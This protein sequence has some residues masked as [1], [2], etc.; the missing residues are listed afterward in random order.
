MIPREHLPKLIAWA[1][2]HDLALFPILAWSKQPTGIVG[3]HAHNWSK[4]PAQWMK[5]YEETGGCNF[6]VE[7]GPSKLIVV[8]VDVGGFEKF[9]EWWKSRFGCEPVTETVSTPTG[10]AHWYFR[11][12]DEWTEEQSTE[13]RQPN[14]CGKEVNTRAGR[15]YV[16]APW[17]VTRKDAD[18]GVKA[19]GAYALA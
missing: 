13:L 19:D 2:S 15:G 1:K 14:L 3:S 5:W 8:D 7:C 16:V 18:N 4:D 17:S 6:G 11:L 12:P 10:G 9:R